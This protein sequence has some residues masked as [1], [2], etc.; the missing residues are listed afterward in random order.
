MI[1]IT[2]LP[3]ELRKRQAEISADPSDYTIVSFGILGEIFPGIGNEDNVSLGASVKAL[4][5]RQV[6]APLLGR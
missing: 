5:L 3:P 2:L 4:S 1:L 6:L